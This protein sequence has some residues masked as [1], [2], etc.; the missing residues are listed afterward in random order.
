MQ[1]L[2]AAAAAAGAAA[3]TSSVGFHNWTGAIIMELQQP[4]CFNESL[5]RVSTLPCTIVSRM[6]DENVAGAVEVCFYVTHSQVLRIRR[7]CES[8]PRVCN[9]INY[10]FSPQLQL[11]NEKRLSKKQNK[12]LCQWLSI[13]LL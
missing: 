3:E 2:A 10:I 4:S 12:A 1:F 5:V 6:N 13:R 8:V 9:I 7:C 11:S